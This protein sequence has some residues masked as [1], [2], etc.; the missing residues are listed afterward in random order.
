MI[1]TR[2]QIRAEWERPENAEDIREIWTAD[3]LRWYDCTNSFS[4]DMTVVGIVTSCIS[5]GIGTGISILSLEVPLYNV[6]TIAGFDPNRCFRS[7]I[8]D[9]GVW[10]FSLGQ[11]VSSSVLM[12]LPQLG[13]S[14]FHQGDPR[15]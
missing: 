10:Q 5:A 11:I 15:S 14:H 8:F 7:G 4:A 13:T 9:N 6:P 2:G 3:L 1:L 12:G